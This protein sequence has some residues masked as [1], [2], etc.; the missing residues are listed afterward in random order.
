ML[1]LWRTRPFTPTRSTSSARCRPYVVPGL[2]AALART[3]VD[4]RDQLLPVGPAVVVL[5]AELPV[6]AQTARAAAAAC[7]S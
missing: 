7:C 3:F 1:D 6:R 5:D 4:T 2:R